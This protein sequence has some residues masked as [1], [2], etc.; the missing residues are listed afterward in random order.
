MPRK[1]A[2]L[3]DEKVLKITPNIHARIKAISDQTNGA[4]MRS[5][6]DM[7]LEWALP[8]FESGIVKLGIIE[9]DSE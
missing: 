7:I 4:T 6:T 2:P 5:T 1:T 8:S 3:A 9:S